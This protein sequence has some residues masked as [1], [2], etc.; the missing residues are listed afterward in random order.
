VRVRV[1]VWVWV[2]VR[3]RVRVR[4]INESHARK[5]SQFMPERHQPDDSECGERRVGRAEEQHALDAR[6]RQSTLEPAH[7]DVEAN[8]QRRKPELA[9]PS[10]WP[11]EHEE[12]DR[13][14]QRV[15]ERS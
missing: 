9:D 8:A 12:R 10:T 2:R 3:V 1:R 14:R 15:S 13:W 4:E 6:C 7:A 11:S 5:L